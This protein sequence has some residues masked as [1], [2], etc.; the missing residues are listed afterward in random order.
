VYIY[1]YISIFQC[2]LTVSI[3]KRV[4]FHDTIIETRQFELLEYISLNQSDYKILFQMPEM[5]LFDIFESRT[6][7]Q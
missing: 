4:F 7:K 1:S 6:C 2:K 3:V 5:L